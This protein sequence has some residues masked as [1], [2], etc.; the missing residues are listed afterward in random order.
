MLSRQCV[1][2]LRGQYVFSASVKTFKQG[3]LFYKHRMYAVNI[4]LPTIIKYYI[5]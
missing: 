4:L 5:I 1:Y 3:F 2:F